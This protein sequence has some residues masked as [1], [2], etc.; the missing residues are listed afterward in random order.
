MNIRLVEQLQTLKEELFMESVYSK[1]H[2][3]P[4]FIWWYSV[5]TEELECFSRSEVDLH[6]C[7]KFTLPK[8]TDVGK[9]IKGRIYDDVGKPMVMIYYELAGSLIS[10]QIVQKIVSSL[11]SET[12]LEFFGIYDE[13]G[14]EIILEKK[15]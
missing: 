12:G 14:R 1:A 5:S 4:L 7:E 2:S 10:N 15:I 9:L 6:T 11:K 3:N 13:S 8:R